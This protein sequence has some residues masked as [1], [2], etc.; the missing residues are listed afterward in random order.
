M[1]QEGVIAQLAVKPGGRRP[2]FHVFLPTNTFVSHWRRSQNSPKTLRKTNPRLLRYKSPAAGP[3]ATVVLLPAREGKLTPTKMSLST[4]LTVQIAL[5]ELLGGP[6]LEDCGC[7][8]AAAKNILMSHLFSFFL[9]LLRPAP[10][11]RLTPSGLIH[12]RRMDP[13]Q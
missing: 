4:F 3:H 8:G 2:E 10:S 13:R 7:T 12:Q 1:T 5:V 11:S 6:T 9:R